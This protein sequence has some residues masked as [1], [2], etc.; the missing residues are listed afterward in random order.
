PPG[1]YYLAKAELY[2]RRQERDT[3]SVAARWSALA[4]AYFDSARVLLE[5]RAHGPSGAA[6]DP[7][8]H[9][10]LGE[11]Y[12]GI[13]RTTEGLRE[14]REAFTVGPARTDSTTQA[15]LA[16]LAIRTYAKAGDFTRALDLV[17]QQLEGHTLISRAELLPLPY[18]KP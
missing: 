17:S 14:A 3:G 4:R 2:E 16:I 11:A 7:F 15:Y 12:V 9:E 1:P 18:F 8:D 13:G 10:D 5:Q 6:S